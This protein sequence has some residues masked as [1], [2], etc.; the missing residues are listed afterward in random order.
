MKAMVV[1]YFHEGE[2]W[3]SDWARQQI[4]PVY[5]QLRGEPRYRQLLPEQLPEVFWTELQKS[6]DDQL[7]VGFKV[8]EV[9][10]KN[11]L[12]ADRLY[13]DAPLDEAGNPRDSYRTLRDIGRKI[14]SPHAQWLARAASLQ[15]PICLLKDVRKQ[16]PSSITGIASDKMNSEWAAA[17]IGYALNANVN[18]KLPHYQSRR[19]SRRD[20]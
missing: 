14:V 2:N 3:D 18:M 7:M 17:L 6:V 16:V 1:Y 11:R 19:P 12:D 20:A 4:Q 10:T 9:M 15:D 13:F 8:R 5:D